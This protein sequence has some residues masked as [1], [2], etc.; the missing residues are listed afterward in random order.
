DKG[1]FYFLVRRIA[2]RPTAEVLPE[3]LSKSFA[4]LPWPK[5]MRWAYDSQRWVRPLHGIVAVFDG[6]PLEGSFTMGEGRAVAFGDA[7]K[8]H[9]FLAP[10]PFSVS[11]F[12][13]YRDRLRKAKVVL[14]PAERRDMIAQQ[15]A[16]LAK[17]A[18]VTAKA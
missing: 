17:S 8:G 7:T 12:A 15:A 13:D 9:R 4:E 6:K 2:G 11:S 16:A 18:G 3:I 14:D 1:A 10:D 5:S